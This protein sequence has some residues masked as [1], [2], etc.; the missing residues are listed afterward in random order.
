MNHKNDTGI[1]QSTQSYSD[2]VT[3]LEE[4]KRGRYFSFC[5]GAGA[6]GSEVMGAAAAVISDD[7]IIGG[8]GKKSIT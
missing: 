8:V 2:T 7:S 6:Q 1:I 5:G 4:G 3:Y